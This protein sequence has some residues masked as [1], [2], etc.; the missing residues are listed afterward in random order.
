MM[1]IMHVALSLYTMFTH[2]CRF[3]P[4]SSVFDCDTEGYTLDLQP[5][6]GIY[7][8][9]YAVMFNGVDVGCMYKFIN[10]V[11]DVP[12]WF[13]VTKSIDYGSKPSLS[14]CPLI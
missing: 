7:I 14:N 1:Y 3:P 13:P 9:N 6:S 2:K 5:R 8:C 10:L 4:I 11:G 12:D